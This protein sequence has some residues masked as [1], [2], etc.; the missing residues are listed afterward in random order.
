MLAVAA[1]AVTPGN[2]A[3]AVNANSVSLENAAN[4]QI[5][6]VDDTQVLDGP[7][8]ILDGQTAP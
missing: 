8:P 5:V 2:N 3:N 1:L 6:C 7:G 4:S